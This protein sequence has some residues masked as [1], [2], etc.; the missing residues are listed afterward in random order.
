MDKDHPNHKWIITLTVMTGTIMSAIDMSIVNVAL[1]HMRGSLGAS[2]EEISWVSIGYILSNVIIMP[3]VALLSS[4]FG[5]KRFYMFSVLLFTLASMLCGV[6]WSL[7]SMITFRIIQGIGG[8]ALIPVSQAILRET[9]PPKEQAMAMGIYGVGVILGPAIG[10]TL[11]GWLTDNYSWPWIFYINVP[12]GI[13]NTILVLK[14]IEDPPY[15]V[16][17]RTKL[18]IAGLLFMAVGLGALQILLEKGEQHDWFA[19]NFII[20][21][22][23]ISCATLLLFVWRELTSDSPAV[24][25]KILKDINFSSATFLG[26]ILGMALMSS[27]FI[28]PLLL[29]Q[30]LGY[31]AFESGI[32]LM[33]RSIAMA[34]TMP[35]GGR[36]YNRLGPRILI[37]MGLFIDAVSFFQFSQFSLDVGTRNMFLPQFLQ[38]IGFGFIFVSLSTAALSTIEKS[39]MTAA[40]GLY[41]VVRQIFGSIGIALAATILTRG[42]NVYRA[43]IV[44]NLTP[45]NNI[46]SK[47]LNTLTSY[48]TSRGADASRAKGMALKTMDGM[49]YKQSSMLSYNHIFFIIAVIFLFSIPLVYFI[50]DA[51]M[52]GK[53]VEAVSE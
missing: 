12:I 3:I 43:G 18:D 41:N 6:A 20:F 46:A 45:Y 48:F 19:S 29:Q 52:R 23:F 34:I 5:R 37:S 15:L 28:L 2:V 38:G 42:E 8:G 44:K 33:P 21:L 36:L 51:R 1:P 14:F 24:N 49:L 16:R 31:T 25:L 22:T 39:A 30:L 27:I 53:P 50:R 40:T 47:Y 13:I 11:G 32:A 10:P 35:I 7:G 4:W 26:G 9:F 17:E